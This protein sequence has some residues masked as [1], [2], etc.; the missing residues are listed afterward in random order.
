MVKNA[1]K[2]KKEA[3]FMMYLPYNNLVEG[4]IED[5]VLVQG[6]V[7]LLIEEDDGFIIVDYKFSNLPISV[8]K[9]KYTEQLELYKKATEKA[10]N[11]PVKQTLIYS[12]NTGELL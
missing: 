10:F 7:D 5:K 2:I 3:E 11:K 12:I 9:Q 6:V 1:I 4:D 8:L